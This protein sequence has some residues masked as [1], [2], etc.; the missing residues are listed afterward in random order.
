[1][2]NLQ[3]FKFKALADKLQDELLTGDYSGVGFYSQDF[4]D[5]K[6]LYDRAYTARKNTIDY[7]KAG[8]TDE[9]VML[10]GYEYEIKAKS[11]YSL[12]QLFIL[13]YC[14]EHY[15][16]RLDAKKLLAKFENN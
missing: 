2:T 11:N 6:S 3:Y 9:M 5:I 12:E 16:D 8:Y 10:Y 7:L 14:S 13:R 15:V 1:M 4:S